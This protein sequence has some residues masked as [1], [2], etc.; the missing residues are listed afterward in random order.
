MVVITRGFVHGDAGIADEKRAISDVFFFVPLVSE[1]RLLL[2]CLSVFDTYRRL[3]G[4]TVGDVEAVLTGDP[5]CP[6]GTP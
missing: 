2:L 6:D 3:M 4:P 1:G 5:R